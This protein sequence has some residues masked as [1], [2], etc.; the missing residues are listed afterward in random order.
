M[1]KNMLIWLAVI[2]IVLA[3]FVGYQAFMDVAKKAESGVLPGDKAVELSL[4]D[5]QGQLVNINGS[6]DHRIYVLN[7]WATWCPPCQ[8]E[9]PELNEFA[10]EHKDEMTF[11][12]VNIQEPASKVFDFLREHDYRMPV[13]LDGE[14]KNAETYRVQGI[15]TT[16]IIDNEGVIQYRKTGAVTKAEL[17]EKL[18]KILEGR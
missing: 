9:M 10:Q 4:Q 1:K 14:G 5:L 16:I 18:V 7:F 12:A 11:Y 3:G 13:L 6:Q 15:P 17:E 2:F 8:G